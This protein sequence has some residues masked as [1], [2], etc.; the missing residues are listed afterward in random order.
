VKKSLLIKELQFLFRLTILFRIAHLGSLRLALSRLE[1]YLGNGYLAC[2]GRN[3]W[4]GIYLA[5]LDNRPALNSRIR[6]Q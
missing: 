6:R 4:L 1:K 3:F 5:M 2:F